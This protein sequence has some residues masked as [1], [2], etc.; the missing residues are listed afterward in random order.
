MSSPYRETAQKRRQ[1][2][3]LKAFLEVATVTWAAK[4]AG[5]GRR[6]HYDWLKKDEGYQEAFSQA[7][8]VA[9]DAL[10]EEARKRAISGKSDVLLMFLMKGD[11]PAKYRDSHHVTVDG[12][13]NLVKLMNEGR[14]RVAEDE[15]AHGD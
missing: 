15:K 5:I 6:T 7:E 14:N 1:K 2:T 13:I 12:T 11:N 4:A 8:D 3:F 9:S 10:Y